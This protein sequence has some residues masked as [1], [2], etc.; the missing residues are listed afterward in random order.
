[1][2]WE[3]L[4]KMTGAT[5]LYVLI[6]GLLWKITHQKKYSG[7]GWKIAVGLIYGGCS[8]FANHFGI[9]YYSIL[10]LNVRDIGPLA[11]GLFFSPMSGV[12]A[13][14][15]G[16]AERILAGE[17]WGIGTFT[18]LACGM[19]TFLA[20]ILA[21][22]MNR[23]VYQG[24]RPPM[25]PS[26]FLGAVTEVFHMYAVLFTNRDN[27]T[28]AYFVVETAAVPMISFTAIGLALCSMAVMKLA[29]ETSDI[30]WRM[31]EEKIPLAILFQRALLAVTIGLFL[32]NFLISYHLQK[33][34]AYEDLS[35]RLNYY[36]YEK[37]GI[38]ENTGDLELLRKNVR[39]DE[40]PNSYCL[41][42]N[43]SDGSFAE[44]NDPL[45]ID[46][47]NEEQMEAV[48]N[49]A[50]QGAF[51][52]AVTNG[53][54]YSADMLC[55][56]SAVGSDHYLVVMMSTFSLNSDLE[57]KMYETTLS[58]ILIFTVLFM[59]VSM[60]SERLVVRNLHRINTSLRKITGGH[61]EETVWVHS[62]A[63]FT[64]LSEDINKTVTALR[65]YIS[66]AEERIRDELK[67]AAAIQ[68]S[69]L[70]KNFNLPSKNIDLYALMTPAKQVGGDFYDFFYIDADKLCLVIADVS[71]KGVPASLF[72]MRAMTAIKNAALSGNGPAEVLMKVNNLLCEGND[73]E[74][75]VTVWIGILD[76]RTGRIECANAGHEYPV[77]M[78][79]ET[80]Y[81]LLKD[82]HGLVLAAMPDIPMRSYEIQLN[83]GDRL[84]VYTDGVPEA[85]NEKAEAYGTGR[86]V[87]RLNRQRNSTQQKTL[88]DVLQDIRNFAGSAEQFD[89]I[90][91]LGL[92]YTDH[93]S[94]NPEDRN[95]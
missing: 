59:L 3:M 42:V 84:F 60:L 90:T 23:M 7:N 24:R 66:A 31:P 55:R 71:G 38:Y 76:L 87:Q 67:L 61:L 18:E 88:E 29:K 48:R 15:I 91:M 75:F 45:V 95:T 35:L 14:T 12:I 72:M 51:L 54:D 5:L 20:G 26:F 64:E 1:M 53:G 11:A 22:I 69:A 82:R 36:I 44:E 41:L 33:R 89:D 28:E 73:A 4:L 68:D 57:A 32:I 16:G 27:M 2:E 50:D 8:V 46:R 92:T 62:S 94:L 10:V 19:S 80:G 58:D 40:N 17:L 63:E 81:E 86:L 77:V 21:A 78:R 43:A 37:E 56:S 47:L 85:I 34:L 79:S 25:I 74:M 13:G 6:T 83:P 52:I 93:G 39:E 49:N 70:P 30:G 9:S 65:G